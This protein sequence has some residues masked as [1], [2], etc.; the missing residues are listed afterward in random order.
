[1]NCVFK[2]LNFKITVTFSM[3]ILKVAVES[4]ILVSNVSFYIMPEM[5]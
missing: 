4:Y 2:V 5:T 3:L 1:M